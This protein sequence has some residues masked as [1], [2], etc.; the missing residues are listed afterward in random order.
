MKVNLA[1]LLHFELLT[2]LHW[3]RVHLL[4]PFDHIVFPSSSLLSFESM[5]ILVSSQS[6]MQNCF[7]Y[8]LCLNSRS[9]ASYK[10]LEQFKTLVARKERS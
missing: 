6:R 1:Y 8:Y 3:K 5:I 7:F 9:F 4:K 10:S 2:K